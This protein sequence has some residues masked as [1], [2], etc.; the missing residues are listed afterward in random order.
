M[1]SKRTKVTELATNRL[2]VSKAPQYAVWPPFLPINICDTIS[3][4]MKLMQTN[5][6]TYAALK[7]KKKQFL[8]QG[9]V[10]GFSVFVARWRQQNIWVH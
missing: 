9:S 1:F 3:N 7:C 10:P 2:P 8:P 4:N 6:V 5:A